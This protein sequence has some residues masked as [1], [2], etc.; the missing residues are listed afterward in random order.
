[1]PENKKDRRWYQLSVIVSFIAIAS[2][3]LTI[4]GARIG[5]PLSFLFTMTGIAALTLPKWDK[6]QER[7]QIIAVNLVALCIESLILY[8]GLTL[9]QAA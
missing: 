9:S 6:K 5:Y 7:G 1:M 2:T 8:F 3:A 4:V